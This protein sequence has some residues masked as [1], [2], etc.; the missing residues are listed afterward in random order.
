MTTT[1][2]PRTAGLAVTQS[3]S[4][5]TPLR[6]A[7]PDGRSQRN[8]PLMRRYEI[9]H[10]TPSG[11]IADLQ[12]LAPATQVFEDAFA[13]IGRGGVVQTAD[14]PR[15]V[16][17]LLPG[18]EVQT[19]TNGYQSL[20]W[21]GS[22][23]IVPGAQNT[24]YEMGTLTRITADALGLSRPSPD[25]ILGPSARIAHKAPGIRT[26]TGSEAALVPARD[27][28]DQTQIIELTPATPV[29]VYQLG[30]AQH[31]RFAV[32]GVEI[33]SLHPGLAHTLN[34][35]AD[36][37]ALLMTLFPHKESLFDFGSM[38]LPRIRLRDLDLFDAA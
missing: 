6:D 26:L 33:E 16:E 1:P 19:V 37:M 24:R 32:N 25:L 11:G 29:Q 2:S 23:T 4:P 34:L 38:A 18:D 9:A 22:I 3:S 30:F 27:F 8:R 10:L 28:I 12:H 7:S 20:L 5:D 17:D 36:A 14:G 15:A 35:R 13:A 31:E 21:I